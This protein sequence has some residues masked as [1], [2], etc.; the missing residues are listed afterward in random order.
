MTFKTICETH[1]IGKYS[2]DL[3]E[4]EVGENQQELY[5]ILL[6]CLKIFVSLRSPKG[7]GCTSICLQCGTFKQNYHCLFGRTASMHEHAVNLTVI[8]KTVNHL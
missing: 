5:T 1:A 4:S 8:T 3:I 6:T 7:K 2:Q